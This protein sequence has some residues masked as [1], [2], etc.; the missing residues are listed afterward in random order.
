[1]TRPAET[2]PLL[3]L[4]ASHVR[5][6]LTEAIHSLHEAERLVVTF[7]YY[8]ALTTKEIT[9]LLDRTE[10]SV[11]QIHASGISQLLAKLRL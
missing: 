11:Q 4:K 5:E 6:R 10:S 3:P 9:F 2:D 1:L 8:E 7:Y